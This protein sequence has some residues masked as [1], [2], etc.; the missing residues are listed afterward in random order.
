MGLTN[1]QKLIKRLFDLILSL[2][3]LIFL[4]WFI[5]ILAIAA[6]MFVRGTGFFKQKRVGLHSNSFLIYKIKSISDEGLIT[7]FGR[8]LR[9]TKLDELPQLYNILKG[10]MSF[11][12]PRPDIPGYADKLVGEDRI[13]LLVRPGIT[14]PASIYFKN[15][16][17]ILKKQ[18]NP[19][20]YNDEVIWPQKVAMN[21]EYIKNYSFLKDLVCLVKTVM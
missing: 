2:I 21:V 12:G 10:D 18:L 19:K 1:Q 13:I 8:F 3:S 7:S 6:K 14:S 16:E 9:K 15:E 4:G 17:E 5:V 20:K 11:V